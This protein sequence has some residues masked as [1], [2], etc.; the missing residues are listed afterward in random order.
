VRPELAGVK[1]GDFT[2]RHRSIDAGK[3]AMQRAMPQL[4]ALIEA[5]SR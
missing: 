3:L 4:R 1:G 2:A 5:K